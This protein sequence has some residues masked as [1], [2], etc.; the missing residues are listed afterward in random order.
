MDVLS[1]LQL[2]AN[3]TK[4]DQDTRNDKR[5][6]EKYLDDTIKDS[7]VNKG[8]PRDYHEKALNLRDLKRIMVGLTSRKNQ[9][10]ACGHRKLD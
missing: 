10:I 6:V 5:Q 3:L 2:N 9:F 7:I 8:F 4:I 1:D